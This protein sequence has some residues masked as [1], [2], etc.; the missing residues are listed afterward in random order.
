MNLGRVTGTLVA[1]RKD[2]N[3]DGLAM[4]VVRQL[5]AEGNDAGGY[6]VAVDSVGAGVGE[7]VL[8]ASGSSARQTEVTRDKPCD[9]VI[10]AIVDQWDLDGE[11]VY[12]K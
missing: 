1:T 11:T 6:V 4:L 10:M 2:P 5:T 7:V 9:A 3:L 8:Y 12:V